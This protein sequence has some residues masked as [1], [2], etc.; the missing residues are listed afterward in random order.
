MPSLVHDA[1]LRL[2]TERYM[3][4]GVTRFFPLDE[5]KMLAM[6]FGTDNVLPRSGRRERAPNSRKH[7]EIKSKATSRSPTVA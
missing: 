5:L 6:E 3:T 4:M 2:C 7:S 1:G